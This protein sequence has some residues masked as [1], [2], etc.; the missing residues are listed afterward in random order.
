MK[1]K[2]SFLA[3]DP[4]QLDKEWL[5]QSELYYKHARRLAMR[6]QDLDNA[7][8]NLDVV[9]AQVDAYVRSHPK[10]YGWTSK[11]TEAVVGN[12]IELHPDYQKA[13]KAVSAAKYAM[14][15]TQAAVNALEHRKRALTLLVELHTQS[16]F[17]GPSRSITS[18]RVDR[19]MSHAKQKA[20]DKRA[21]HKGED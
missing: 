14:D 6:K 10:K 3:I 20:Q 1:D 16:Y 17:S 15:V 9:T 19:A 4:L 5:G 7:N 12:T 13:K 8:S 18:T 2:E 21:R 11:P